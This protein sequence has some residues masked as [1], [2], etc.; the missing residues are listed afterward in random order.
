MNQ[1][2]S[3]Y[4]TPGCA[5]IAA[6]LRAIAD[7][8]E[9][10]SYGPLQTGALV[11]ARTEKTNSRDGYFMEKLEYTSFCFGPRHDELTFRGLLVLAQQDPAGTGL[12]PGE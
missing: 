2:E 3:L 10:G 11:L 4:E 5:D 6:A 9:E 12:E 1:V 7:E 8:I